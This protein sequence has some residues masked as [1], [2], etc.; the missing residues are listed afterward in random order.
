MYAYY[1]LNL[2]Y[3]IAGVKHLAVS[4]IL[5]FF[6]WL[7]KLPLLVQSPREWIVAGQRESHREYQ[8]IAEGIAEGMRRRRSGE[9]TTDKDNAERFVSMTEAFLVA[10]EDA[11]TVNPEHFR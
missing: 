5:N 8:R 4:G 3:P 2:L 6:P 11:T 10:R 1:S 7:E 9:E